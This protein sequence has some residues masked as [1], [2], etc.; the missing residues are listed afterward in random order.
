[1]GLI[2]CPETT[3]RNYHYSLRNSPE[4]RSSQVPISSH[5]FYD[6]VKIT[7]TCVYYGSHARVSTMDL[8][9]R[10]YCRSHA[11][12]STMDH[13]ITLFTRS[14]LERP[15]VFGLSLV[16]TSVEYPTPHTP[17]ISPLHPLHM[18]TLAGVFTQPVI[19]M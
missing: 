2:G 18:P 7:C 13:N 9:A 14:L 5:V 3:V 17:A 11:R 8:H 15:D 12:V 19:S 1:M 16:P 4:E 6:S 10:V